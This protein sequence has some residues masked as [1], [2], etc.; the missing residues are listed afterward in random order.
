M[1]Q[2]P[3]LPPSNAVQA[4]PLPGDP[5]LPPNHH[6][7]RRGISTFLFRIPIPSS[8]PSSI[9]FGADLAQ[10]KYEVR[11]S[12]GVFWKG[13]KRLVT[14]KKDIEVVESYEHDFSRAEP[15]AVVVGEYGKIWAQGKLV[16]GMAVAGES[17]C[18][19]LQV[20]NHS[21]KKVCCCECYALLA[22]ILG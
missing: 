20:K 4:H 7:A 19:E 11:A 17:A 2:G 8:A 3:G 6:Q 18:V 14:N 22:D 15:E 10:V 13:E 9:S 5:P 12:V 1:F 16:G 21:N